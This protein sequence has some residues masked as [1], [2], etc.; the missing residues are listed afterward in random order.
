MLAIRGGEQAAA[1][2]DTRGR[3]LGHADQADRDIAIDLGKLIPVDH[4]LTAAGRRR[5]AA[6]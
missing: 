4:S 1:D 3:G 6:A 5:R 2:F